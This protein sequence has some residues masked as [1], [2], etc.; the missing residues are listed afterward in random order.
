MVN[1]SAPPGREKSKSDARIMRV[2][3]DNFRKSSVLGI[4]RP[5]CTRVYEYGVGE[6]TF[7]LG[8][9]GTCTRAHCHCNEKTVEIAELLAEHPW[10]FGDYNLISRNCEGFAN[11]CKTTPLTVQ[12]IRDMS[13]NDVLGTITS[14]YGHQA[15]AK[16][17]VYAV[18]AVPYAAVQV[19]C[20][21]VKWFLGR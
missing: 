19:A 13:R 12:Q 4:P 1:F 10:D 18:V 9:P 6:V 2:S 17:V 11:F 8:R 3:L 14:G 5:L 21:V 20:D 7:E 15:T 16:Q